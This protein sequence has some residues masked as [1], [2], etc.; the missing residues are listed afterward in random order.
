[1]REMTEPLEQGEHVVQ[2]RCGVDP[3]TWK[4]DGQSRL[5]MLALLETY[6]LAEQEGWSITRGPFID[7]VM[8]PNIFS[9]HGDIDVT[10]VVRGSE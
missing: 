7:K 8:P 6:E 2:F 9:S 3:E 10:V 5:R 1:M 4:Q